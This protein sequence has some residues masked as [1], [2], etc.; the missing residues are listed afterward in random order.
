[1]STQIKTPEQIAEQVIAANYD[2]PD[3]ADVLGDLIYARALDA[4]DVR[5]LITGAIEA[6]RAQRAE[7][8]LTIELDAEHRPE[9]AVAEVLSQIEDGMTSG[10]YPTWEMNYAAIGE[11]EQ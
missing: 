11:G 1:M 9:E 5:S 8:T 7:N 2:D 3:S 6:D 4:D 10:Y